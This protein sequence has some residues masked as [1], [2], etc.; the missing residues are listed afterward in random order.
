[1]RQNRFAAEPLCGRTALRQKRF[2][3][4]G[5]TA[6]RGRTVVRQDRFA[7]GS[8]SPGRG[9]LWS[10]GEP[11]QPELLRG[12]STTP[13]ASGR[14]RAATP[15]GRE[16]EERGTQERENTGRRDDPDLRGATWGSGAPDSTMAPTVPYSLSGPAHGFSQGAFAPPQLQALGYGVGM[17]A[18]SQLGEEST[19]EQRRQRAA[20][21]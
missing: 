7:A 14:P 21:E 1:M 4:C 19:E 8:G 9:T 20:H 10:A 18:Q 17:D 13:T 11:F 2:A 3:A 15:L 16:L 6:F 5:R 12:F